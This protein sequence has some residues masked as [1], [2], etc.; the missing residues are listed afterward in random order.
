MTD[1]SVD[2][3]KILDQLGSKIIP[4]GIYKT[5]WVVDGYLVEYD[6]DN[7]RADGIRL[8]MDLAALSHYVTIGLSKPIGG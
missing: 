7:D 5:G 8:L 6:N 2:T 4:K 3:I 1:E